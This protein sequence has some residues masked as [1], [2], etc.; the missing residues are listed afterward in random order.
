MLM[1][2]AML[3]VVKDK[4]RKRSSLSSR[5]KSKRNLRKRRDRDRLMRKDVSNRGL[6]KMPHAK[7][8]DKPNLKQNKK[9]SKPR[10]NLMK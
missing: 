10:I 5:L 9:K 3:P 4:L 1:Q 2:K 7:Q 8:R 6:K